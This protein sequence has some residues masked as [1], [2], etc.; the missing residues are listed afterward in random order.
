MVPIR[1]SLQIL[2]YRQTKSEGMEKVLYAHGSQ[3]KARG[4]ILYQTK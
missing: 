4:A 1:E 3:K 2:R